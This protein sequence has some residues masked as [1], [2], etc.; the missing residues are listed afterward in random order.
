MQSH[1][2][3]HEKHGLHVVFGAGG[4]GGALVRELA[5]QGKAV[6]AV[7]RSGRADVPAGVEVIAADA[8]DPASTRAACAGVG[9]VYHAVNVPYPAWPDLLPPVMD[10][11]IAAAGAA[12]A[13]LVYVDNAYAYGPVDRPM[14]EDM[15]LSATTKKGRLRA[16]L[17]NTLLAA[18]RAGTV[19]AVIGRGSDYFGPG[20]TNSVAGDR[21]FPAILSGKKAMWAGSLDQPHTMTYVKDFARVLITLGSRPEAQGQVWHAPAAEPLTGRQF[22]TLASELAGQP[23]RPGTYSPLLIRL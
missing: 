12:N 13:T 2:P 9:V 18:H 1:Q 4:A 22:L 10:S 8:A 14:T 21:V 15:P 11:L 17:A 19:R 7:T 16:R 23:P 3:T 6:R 20:V 5:A